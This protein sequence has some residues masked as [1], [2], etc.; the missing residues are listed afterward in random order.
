[1]ANFT[2]DLLRKEFSDVRQVPTASRT[3]LSLIVPRENDPAD[4]VTWT[5]RPVLDQD[6]TFAHLEPWLKEFDRI[7][8][9]SMT[10]RERP[11]L[12]R[13]AD[14]FEGEICLMLS[15][16]QC[17]HSGGTMDLL[18]KIDLASLHRSELTSLTG[19][20]D[21]IAGINALRA[22]NIKASLLV[23][24]GPCGV[25]GFLNGEWKYS[26]AYSIPA[27]RTSGCGDTF[28]GAF[29]AGVDQ[30]ES[31]QKCL[32][33]AC[34][35]AA[36]NAGD[37]PHIGKWKQLEDFTLTN[38]SQPYVRPRIWRKQITRTIQRSIA[39]LGWMTA[40]AAATL[41]MQFAPGMIA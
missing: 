4:S 40:G 27:K 7:V 26:P 31:V 24:D 34:A 1:L 11:L 5:N 21:I 29:L 15:Q 19:E 3:R 22:M 6:A 8:F 13:I 35:A 32:E 23:T 10:D 28:L 30:G 38:P 36:L 25:V 17:A 39:P 41:L 33:L 37:I 16:I 18:G 20:K 14:Q 9:A 12:N 2:L